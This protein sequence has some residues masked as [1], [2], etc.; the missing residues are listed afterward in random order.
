MAITLIKFELCLGIEGH[1]ARKL[2]GNVSRLEGPEDSCTSE[3][4]P[5]LLFD[6]HCGSGEWI[7]EKRVRCSDGQ[8]IA[9]CC[10]VCTQVL[11]GINNKNPETDIRG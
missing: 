11:V 3:Q 4:S 6:P 8:E 5:V 9:Q 2:Y 1:N 10:S 7:V